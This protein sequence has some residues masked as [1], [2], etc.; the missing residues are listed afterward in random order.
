MSILVNLV[1]AVL[2][3]GWGG[4]GAGSWHSVGA[5]SPGSGM[6]S[7][8]H[9][10]ATHYRNSVHR[11]AEGGNKVVLIGTSLGHGWSWAGVVGRARGD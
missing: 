7:I 11:A 3:H 6:R 5:V 10:P 1:A 2:E 4:D 9:V 8:I